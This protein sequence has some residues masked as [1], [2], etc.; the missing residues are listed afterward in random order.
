MS[1]CS[2]FNLDLLAGIVKFLKPIAEKI[3]GGELVSEEAMKKSSQCKIPS[4]V[5]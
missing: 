3:Q 4:G 2:Y 1:N 5:D